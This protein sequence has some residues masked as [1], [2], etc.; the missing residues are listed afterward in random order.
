MPSEPSVWMLPWLLLKL[1]GALT[2]LIVIVLAFLA[3]LAVMAVVVPVALVVVAVGAFTLGPFVLVAWGAWISYSLRRKHPCPEIP[4][5]ME[6]VE[7]RV[8]LA[9]RTPQ[10][11]AIRTVLRPDQ[12]ELSVDQVG[13]LGL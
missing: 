13:R 4:L 2:G 6:S 7:K 11:V 10:P 12:F 5:S 9:L 1:L 3:I 8:L